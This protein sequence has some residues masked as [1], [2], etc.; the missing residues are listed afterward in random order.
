[1]AWYKIQRSSLADDK[2][3]GAVLAEDPIAMKT[4]RPRRASNPEAGSTPSAL[5][6][7]HLLLAIVLLAPA[8]LALAQDDAEEDDGFFGLGW[9][10]TTQSYSSSKADALAQQLDR[11][12]GVERSD[13]EAAYSSLRLIPEIRWHE[14]D[15]FEG[16]LRLRGR[17][18]LPRIDERLSLVF[19]EDQGE[20]TSYY[21]QN[22]LFRE[23]QSTRVNMEVNLQ[24]KERYRFDF[25]VGLRSSLK[26]R[27]SVRF[28]Y[29]APLTTSVA[30]RLSQTV[31]FIDGKGLGSFT[32]YQV[33][34]GLSD[35]SLLR[36]SNEYRREEKLDGDEWST[37][38]TYQ[39]R[40]SNT[41]GTS[42]FLRIASNTDYDY[43]ELYQVGMR[44][45]GNIA[46]PWLFWEFSPGYQ[47]EK[48]S[49]T[50]SR[51]GSLF[52]SLSLEMAIGR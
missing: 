7:A 13:L 14:N 16:R 1:M 25:R 21:D 33:D 12:F 17:L 35:V 46:R 44:W 51:D 29:E 27:T 42:Y 32:Q 3:P 15:D 5:P 23:S 30:N 52:T 6:S 28:R 39:K 47:W 45:R 10:D 18:H 40:H 4:C 37:S 26:L 50:A 34:H 8:S 36:W 22:S 11:F 19:S 38:F 43:V 31:Y 49:D 20:G 2:C 24:N 48:T 9:L 41:T